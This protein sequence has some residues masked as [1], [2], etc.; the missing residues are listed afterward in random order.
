M[1]EKKAMGE[2]GLEN[3]VWKYAPKE[4]GEALWELLRKI[5]NGEGIPEDWKKGVIC[6]IYKKGDKRIAKNYRG[7]EIKREKL[8][9]KMR[10]MG[11]SEKLTRKIKEIY[12][13]TKN[14]VRVKEHNTKEFWTVR[15]VRQRCSLSSTLFNIY[16]TGLEEDLRKGQVEGIVVGERVWSLTY[17]D[18]IVLM[19][20]SEEQLKEMLMRFKK[21][22]KKAELELST[23]KTKIV[24]YEKRRN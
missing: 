3:E 1:K 15:G 4:V 6:P 18:D 17:A 11:V 19:A 22:L 23:E 5:W 13:E 2:D 21:F 7:E 20:D 12:S 8:K 9:E 14:I 16:V 10:K 24:A